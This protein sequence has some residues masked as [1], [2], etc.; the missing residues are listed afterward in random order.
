MK[1]TPSVRHNIFANF[2]GK[3]WGGIFSLAF[4]PVYIKLMGVEVYGLIGIFLSLSALFALLDMGLNATL[5]RELSRLS[6]AENSAQE[7]RNLVR[8]FEVVYWGVGILI[9]IAVIILAPLLAKYWIN[10]TSISSETIEHALLIMGILL[11]SQ[12]PGS[13]YSGGLMGL[14]RQVVLNVIRSVSI[15]V[16]HFGAVLVLLFISPS[17]LLFFLWQSFVA[18]LTTI[19][20]AI[21]LWKALPKS[22]HRSRF[23]KG[24]LVKNWR[25]ASG[26]M[27]I[28]LVVLVLTQLD[29]IILS[30]MLTL[31][32]FGYY[33]L[34][35]SVANVLIRLVSPIHTALFPRLSQLVVRENQAD[36]SDLYHKGCQLASTTILPIA[37]TLVCFSEEIL[38]IW[39]GDPV[40]VRNTHMLLS[41][42]V[43]GS[44]LNA[45]M[46]LPYTLQL[47]YGWTKLAF[48]KNIVAVI[49]LVPLMVWMVQ[50][51]QG[52]GAAWVWIILN[53]S[54]LIFEVPIMHR[55]LL[56]SEMWKWY[57]ID[58]SFPVIVVFIVGYTS[59]ILMPLDLSK[60][61]GFSWVAI[62]YLIGLLLLGLIYPFT[63][64][65]ILRFDN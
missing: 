26:M 55:R 42:L 54:Y 34:A 21:W 29:K 48:Y 60:Y 9:G 4:I 46:T 44:M 12:W 18:L 27:G 65:R 5:N 36:I 1:S 17:I 58:F 16:Q 40:V 19:V 56:K 49:F 28:S 6:V 13:I 20:L 30:K 51:Y 37:I 7:S 63:R 10:S 39:I 33:M 15:M 43:I 23:D 2:A 57:S 11:A 38:S 64:E 8:T 24:L 22:G 47:A 25:F 53:L 45:L 52:I 62:T 59:Y 14:Q 50:M 32:M 35:F 41:L 61:L 31:E 3:V